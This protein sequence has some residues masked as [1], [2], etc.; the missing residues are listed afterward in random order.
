MPC[1]WDG[2]AVDA[3]LRQYDR[4]T[5]CGK[6]PD[7]GQRQGH[8]VSGLGSG[9]HLVTHAADVIVDVDTGYAMYGGIGSGSN[10]RV[11]NRR[12]RRKNIELRLSEPGPS[13]P[14]GRESWHERGVAIEVVA[15]HAI[16]NDQRDQPWRSHTRLQDG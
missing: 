9:E 3:A 14:Q 5:R 10:S 12:I 7:V 4:A 2:G 8:Q 16:E 6:L 13:L 11:P 15:T 1:K